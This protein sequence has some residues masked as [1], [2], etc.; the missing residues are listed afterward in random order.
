MEVKISRKK[1]SDVYDIEFNHNMIQKVTNVIIRRN[2]KF[3]IAGNSACD[4]DTQYCRDCCRKEA[5]TNAIASLREID[6]SALTKEV[7]YKI[8]N[9]YRTLT[10]RPR[11]AKSKLNRKSTEIVVNSTDELAIKREKKIDVMVA[12]AKKDIVKNRI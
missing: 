3:L 8:W 2:K 1:N 12:E 5:L 7:T 11:W 6:P 10:K 9:T 4:K